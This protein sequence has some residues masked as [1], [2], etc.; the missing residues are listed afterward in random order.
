MQLNNGTL[1]VRLNT[2]S[3]DRT[4]YLFNYN[5]CKRLNI[6]DIYVVDIIRCQIHLR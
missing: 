3:N 1:H 6:S 4:L 2:E 5:V